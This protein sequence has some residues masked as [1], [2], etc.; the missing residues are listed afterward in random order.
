MTKNNKEGN[1]LYDK[2]YF[3]SRYENKSFGFSAD[4][5]RAYLYKARIKELKKFKDS[6]NAS[7]EIASGTGAMSFYLSNLFEKSEGIDLSKSAVDLSK[8]K[9]KDK[10][11]LNF[12]KASAYEL[13]FSNNQFD[14]VFAFD[15]LEHIEDIDLCFREIQRVLCP[16]GIL[17][18]ST[19]NPSSLGA[20]IKKRHKELDSLH[21][22]LRKKQWFGYRDDTHINIQPIKFWREQTQRYGFK[23]IKDG[24]DYWWDAPYVE[25]LPA[26]PQEAVCKILNRILTKISYFYKWNHGENYIGIFRKEES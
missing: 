8:E 19:P 25:W 23:V 11:N 12:H 10:T 7:L 5:R 9:Y 14:A 17:F 24:T 16:G 15:V 2:E 22:S 13:P 26:F 21:I 6:F 4:S 3:V 1:E 20:K 18:I